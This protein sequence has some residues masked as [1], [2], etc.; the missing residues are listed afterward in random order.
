MQ[1]RGRYNCHM[2]KTLCSIIDIIHVEKAWCCKCF[3]RDGSGV[4]GQSGHLGHRAGTAHANYVMFKVYWN[5]VLARKIYDA[6][7]VLMSNEAR[8]QNLRS[9]SRLT[10]SRSTIAYSLIFVLCF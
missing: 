6:V 4:A 3:A 7:S 10:R 5:S 1:R 8:Y 9:Y 2:Y